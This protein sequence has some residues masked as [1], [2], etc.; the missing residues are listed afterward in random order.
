MKKY[1]FLFFLFSLLSLRGNAHPLSTPF[2]DTAELAQ[3][4][5]VL[6]QAGKEW[7]S[8]FVIHENGVIVT[9]YHA[10]KN[11][12]P[13]QIRLPSQKWIKANLLYGDLETDIAFL[14]VDIE[15]LDALEF[16]ETFQV[17][18]WVLGAGIPFFSEVTVKKGIISNIKQK[19]PHDYILIDFA[20]N[21]GDF[22]GPLLNLDGK[23]IGMQ[24]ANT[25]T[26]DVFGLII[27][28]SILIEVARKSALFL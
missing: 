24:F 6:I 1:L 12:S 23:V 26:H 21:P 5:T 8:G 20:F 11:G 2:I 10:I 9:L 4:S 28:S 7:S 16:E 15:G 22:G 3:S 18:E 27:P 13:I 19:N 14:K 17:G 25:T